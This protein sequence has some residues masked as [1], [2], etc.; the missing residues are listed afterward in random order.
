MKIVTVWESKML[1]WTNIGMNHEHFPDTKVRP[2]R[3]FLFY[4]DRDQAQGASPGG[5][6]I[7]RKVLEHKGHYF[8]RR[9][10]YYG[11]IAE[12]PA[13]RDLIDIIV[14]ID[15]PGQED[16]CSPHFRGLDMPKANDPFWEEND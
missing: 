4:L 16:R 11:E 7:E 2:M 13:D 5:P 9:H 12:I 8:V 10:P 1:C 14:F 15:R 6:V 3:G